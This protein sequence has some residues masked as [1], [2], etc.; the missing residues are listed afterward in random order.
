VVRILLGDDVEANDEVAVVNLESERFLDVAFDAVLAKDAE[1]GD[2]ELE[3]EARPRAESEAT[4]ERS[5][6]TRGTFR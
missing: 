1:G 4:L 6:S 5:E 3:S 2:D